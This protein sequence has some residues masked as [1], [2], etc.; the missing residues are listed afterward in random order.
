MKKL[1]TI[2]FSA[3]LLITLGGCE[4]LTKQADDV[5]QGAQQLRTEAEKAAID[6]ATEVEKMADQAIETKEKIEEKVGQAQDAVEET[7]EAA[8]ALKKLT[9]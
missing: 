2:L 8:D 3:L 1:L 4:K 6:A 9:E 5:Q 7:Q